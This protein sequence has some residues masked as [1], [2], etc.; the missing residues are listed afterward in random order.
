[1]KDLTA[2]PDAIEWLGVRYKTILSPEQTGG[3]MSIV[4]SLSPVGSGPPRHVHEAEDETFV[5]ITGSCKVWIEGDA[6]LVGPGES[7]F[8]PRGKSH[9]FK[10]VGDAPSRH[11][12]ILTPGGFEGFFADMASGQFSIPEDMPA[13]EE[14]ARRHNLRFTGPPLE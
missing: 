11:L 12:V 14:S 9:T 2:D 6:R 4:D 3:A 7:V 1:M 5:M 13:I 8:I 10:V